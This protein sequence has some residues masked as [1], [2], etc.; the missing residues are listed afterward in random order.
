M[1]LVAAPA[2]VNTRSALKSKIVAEFVVNIQ[3]SHNRLE[4]QCW[5][6][7]WAHLIGWEKVFNLTS[8]LLVFILTCQPTAFIEHLSTYRNSMDEIEL[9][10]KQLAAMRVDVC[11]TE[12][13]K[14]LKGWETVSF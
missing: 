7:G 9:K 14:K 4:W 12:A 11:S 2:P 5:P 8:N 6:L 3:Y 1:I 10:E 13:L